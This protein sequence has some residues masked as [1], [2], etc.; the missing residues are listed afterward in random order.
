MKKEIGAFS[1]IIFLFVIVVTWWA[2]SSLK[3]PQVHQQPVALAA[4]GTV[5]DEDYA[6]VGPIQLFH[7]T[8]K[9]A[10]VYNG[11]LNIPSCDNYM[12][13]ISASGSQEPH[14]KL[15]FTISHE[16][17]GCTSA[18]ATVSVPFSVTFSSSKASQKPVVDSVNINNMA[19]AFSVVEVAKQ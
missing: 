17:Q 2:V 4:D 6:L 16:A 7:S 1:L 19:A 10:E 18:P 9:G 12:T 14:L 15:S 5:V 3:M 11:S 8:S 13:G